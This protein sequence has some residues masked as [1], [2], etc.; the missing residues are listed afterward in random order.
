M[1]VDFRT[2]MA[3]LPVPVPQGT[4]D[5]E[6]EALWRELA[7]RQPTALPN[8]AREDREIARDSAHPDLRRNQDGAE[9]APVQPEPA[10]GPRPSAVTPG[11]PA[12]VQ[13]ATETAGAIVGPPART[14]DSVDGPGPVGQRCWRCGGWGHDRRTCRGEPVLFCSGCGRKGVMSRA[15][16]RR[17]EPGTLASSGRMIDQATQCRLLEPCLR[18][19]LQGR[20]GA[21]RRPVPRRAA[22]PFQSL[23]WGPRRLERDYS[24][25]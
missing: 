8:L 5:E 1:Y 19:G 3:K 20:R 12:A 10:A 18:C 16:C 15:C 25:R 2:R 9:A 4:F 17:P 21:V 13:P 14:S 6:F 24:R 23:Q 7:P 11:V 22:T